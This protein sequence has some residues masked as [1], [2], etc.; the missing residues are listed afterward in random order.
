MCHPVFASLGP[1]MRS[2]SGGRAVG[3]G[4]VTVPAPHPPSPNPN[5][6]W[7]T[8]VLSVW[9]TRSDVGT[10]AQAPRPSR[11]GAL[12]PTGAYPRRYLG[13]RCGG[14][15]SGT[16]TWAYQTWPDPIFPTVNFVSSPDDPFGLKGGVGCSR[17]GG[18]GEGGFGWDPPPLLQ[19]SPCGPRR[20]RAEH[21]EA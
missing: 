13:G 8:G 20:R 10:P 21:F 5:M 16:Q 2:G 18:G 7:A 19:G 9:G 15:G 14:R 6:T 11:T 12:G 17:T 4:G 1:P 3:G